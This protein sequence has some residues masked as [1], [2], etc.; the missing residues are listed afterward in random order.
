MR[1]GSLKIRE[2]FFARGF[3]RISRVQ[4]GDVNK[5]NGDINKQYDD[6]KKNEIMEII[7]I[8]NILSVCPGHFSLNYAKQY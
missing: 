1:T 3:P 6:P 2:T 8:W 4:D 5:K 7:K